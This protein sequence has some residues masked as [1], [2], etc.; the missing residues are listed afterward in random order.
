M[1]FISTDHLKECP[2]CRSSIS[3]KNMTNTCNINSDHQ[4]CNICYCDLKKK[5]F[6][7]KGQPVGC[8]YCGDR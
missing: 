5:Y 8:I 7:P 6:Q 2:L 4:I 3:E 1:N